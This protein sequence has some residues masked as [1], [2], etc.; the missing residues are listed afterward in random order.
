MVWKFGLWGCGL[1]IMSGVSVL[2]NAESPTTSVWR[3]N[4]EDFLK[5]P[6]SP[7]R[8]PMSFNANG[9]SIFALLLYVSTLINDKTSTNSCTKRKRRLSPYLL[10]GSA[11][12]QVTY[13]W[14][15]R[16]YSA[17]PT[18]TWFCSLGS[19]SRCWFGKRIWANMIASRL[20]TICL[21]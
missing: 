9:T 18:V 20:G 14:S 6:C 13:G 17:A 1:S 19:R 3:Q 4:I 15:P 7:L 5:Y 8:I 12:P 11:R 21:L 10:P 2:Y 16:F